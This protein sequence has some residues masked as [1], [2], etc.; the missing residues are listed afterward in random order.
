MK[1]TNDQKKEFLG[2]M[3]TIR[4]FETTVQNLYLKGKLTG[5]LH[6]YLG[7]EAT[8]VGVCAALK[9]D[10]FIVSTHRGD[11]H[12]IAKGADVKG[13]MAELHGRIT[14]YSHGW[15]GSMH[16]FSRELGI[17]GT[18]GIVGGGL[19]VAVGAAL[20]AKLRK[21]SQVS[22][23]FF[24][25]GA[26]NQGVFHESL[27]I[28]AVKDLPVIFVCE[29]NL[30]ATETPVAVA[31]RTANFA[32][33]AAV[34]GMPGLIADG[35]DVLDVYAKT[36]EAVDRARAGKGPT[37]IES[38][39]YRTCGHYVGHLETGYRSKDELAAWR[40]RDPIK[41]FSHHL[42]ETGVLDDA[43]IS[44]MER[45]VKAQIEAALTFALESP[46]PDPA[47]AICAWTK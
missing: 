44:Q 41:L 16:V 26:A 25:D 37:L 2:L 40:E 22:V 31:T 17:L 9:K 35:N 46:F 12:C 14:G 47:E 34:Y 45:E 28:A 4:Q 1:A 8:A 39:T 38:K 18:N 5:F 21:T 32:D 20:H 33:R 3:M 6:V 10:D 13:M 27:N 23:C 15:G 43:A 42:I 19:P 11:G 7:E 36:C 24:G 30:Y 29:N